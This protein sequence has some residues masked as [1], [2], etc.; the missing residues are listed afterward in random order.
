MTKTMPSLDFKTLQYSYKTGYTSTLE[1]IKNIL[2]EIEDRGQ[3]GVWIYKLPATDI[4]SRAEELA[5]LT[6]MER[7]RLPLYGLPF[8]VKDCIDIAGLPTTSAC[9]DFSYIAP[10]THQAVQAALDAGAILLGKT[11]MDQF[12]TG[13]VGVR[14]PYGIARNPFDDRYIPGGS[15]SGA[16]VSV[17]AGLCSFA[18]GSDTGGSGRVPASY[19][20]VIGLKPTLGLFARSQLVN[21][22]LTFDTVSIY[23]LTA[24]DALNVL[25][26]C[27]GV[28]PE[29][30]YGRLTPEKKIIKSITSSLK[31]AIPRKNLLNFFGNADAAILFNEGL[32]T[33]TNAG[34]ELIEI[35][36]DIFEATSMSMFEEPWLAERYAMVGKFIETNP[37]SV[38]ETVRQI[39]LSARNQ[40]AE[41][42]LNALYTLHRRA[43]KIR[44][45]I[46]NVDL[47]V[48]PTL[49]TVYK[50]EDVLAD[51]ILPNS[52]NGLYTNFV[53]MAD[54][55]A[56]AVPN[57]FLPSG[58][59][60]GI[61]FIGPAFSDSFLATIA[62]QFHRQRVEYLG[63]STNYHPD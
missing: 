34:H 58:I 45:A 52:T 28:E 57:G 61:S 49:G 42:S 16:A 41:K 21:A 11:N 24:L 35:D 5:V 43:H 56:I 3:D 25:E 7:D 8:T 9:P 53:N 23:A 6:Q 44:K 62:N 29:D 60:M 40:T 30:P 54:L 12:A 22:S 2:L 36:Y 51:P 55:A 48:V 13:V 26:A 20:N 63:A 38:N 31:I 37:N 39:I 18:F 19:N 17:S 14:T 1:V 15:S 10:K 33:L 50:I 59:P 47:M 4:L 27:Q 32:D 46:A